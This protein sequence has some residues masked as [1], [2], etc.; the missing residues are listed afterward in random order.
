M[1]S[2]VG[3]NTVHVLKYFPFSSSGIDPPTINTFSSLA[4]DDN[5]LVVSPGIFS[6][7][8]AK[9]CVP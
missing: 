9:Y 6:A 5:A 4:N 3:E 1:I 2:P 8:F 7:Y